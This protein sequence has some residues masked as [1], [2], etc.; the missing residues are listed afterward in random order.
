M[1]SSER[2]MKRGGV[3]SGSCF[4]NM[5]DGI[6]NA[7]VTRYVIYNMTGELLL[8][9]V[10]LG[11]DIVAITEK[12]LDLELFCELAHEQFSIN[13][14]LEKSYQTSNIVNVHFLGYYNIH[15]V[16]YKPTDSIIAS[17]I[18]LERPTE[19]KFETA[20]RLVGQAY[21]CLEP[22]DAKRFFLAAHVLRQEIVGRDT[23]YILYPDFLSTCKLFE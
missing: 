8:D 15:G 18:Y 21:S 17:A 4:T 22:E 2:F 16:P 11:D 12:P 1:S 10:R 3:P 20:V 6:V 9:D 7:I 19:N 5:I 23:W 14:N 13:L